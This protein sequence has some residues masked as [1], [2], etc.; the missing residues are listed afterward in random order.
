MKKENKKFVKNK[1]SVFESDD[2]EGS[3]LSFQSSEEGEEELRPMDKEKGLQM[4]K[5]E[6]ARFFI[7][8]PEL[9]SFKFDTDEDDTEPENLWSAMTLNVLK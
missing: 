9:K 4:F 5:E 3:D 6:M 7:S 2:S 8:N 1:F